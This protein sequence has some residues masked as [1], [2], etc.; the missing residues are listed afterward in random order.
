MNKINLGQATQI[1]TNIGMI[2]GIAFL[3]VEVAQNNEYAATEIRATRYHM[4]LE[5]FTILAE[6]SELA[7][8]MLKDREHE[9]LTELESLQ[10]RAWW[11]RVFL[12][13]QWA[14]SE[15]AVADTIP[16]MEMQRVNDEVYPAYRQAWESRKS[17]FEPD[18]VQFMEENIF[19][20]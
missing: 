16:F 10:L 9:A 7:A 19:N 5:A 4:A 6:N 13:N 3:G 12:T 18:F 15:M 11:L 17:Y 1:L 20:H 8:L 14:H 2:V